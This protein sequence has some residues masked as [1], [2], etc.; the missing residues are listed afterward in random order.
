MVVGGEHYRTEQVSRMNIYEQL[1]AA[2]FS[3]SQAEVDHVKSKTEGL[4]LDE[5]AAQVFVLLLIGDR[6][7]DFELVERVKPG[8][9][10]RFFGEDLDF[11]MDKMK[12]L[13][14]KLPIPPLVTADMEG[15][16]LSFSFGTVV[17]NQLSLAAANDPALTEACAALMARE[18][19][20]L[21]VTWSFTPVIDIN[22]A[23]RSAIVG[24]RSY[25]SDRKTISKHALAHIKGLQENGIAATVKHWPGEGYDDRDQHFVT[26][27]N[28][29][30][31]D[32][33]HSTFGTLYREMFDAG[34]MSVMSAHIAFPA[35]MKALNPDCG[36]DAFKPAS[37]SYD[38]TTRLLRDEMGFNG[39]VVSDATEMA[40]LGSWI[41]RDKAA[42]EVLAAGCDVI[43]FSQDPESDVQAVVEAVRSGHLR[44]ERLNEAVARII[45][46]K[47]KQGILDSSFALP[48]GETLRRSLKRPEDLATAAEAM[49][50]APTL[51]KDVSQTLP[52]TT[53][54]YKR[55][56]VVDN[57]IRHTLWKDRRDFDVP[58]MLREKGFEVIRF[59][60]DTF[61]GKLYD[62][63][64]F[65]L[66]LYLLGDESVFTKSHIYIDWRTMI[67]GIERAMDRAWNTLP[68]VMVGFGHPYYLYDA[69][70]VPTYVNAYSTLPEMQQSVVDCLTGKTP[71]QGQSPVDAF[72]GLEDA[73]Y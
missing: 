63:D 42:P 30:T 45:A 61:E 16:H 64:R 65:D 67:G 26:T 29:L 13:F 11:E 50:R 36:V 44:E 12:R 55:I 17:P 59:D 40:G 8:G 10:T 28:P 21:G 48:D 23:F 33:W 24:S 37:I 62:P 58:R 53:E 70:R 52:L 39:I 25:G 51:V 34:V 15:S 38:L 1:R 2:P 66:V 22:V 5:K 20:Q 7:Q 6:E 18:A 32:E 57:Q 46:L 4:S 41:A 27:Q 3:L 47:L 72:C 68:T 19:R 9:I 69:P 14:S 73:R 71:F 60:Q 56:L 43:L 35:Y 54:R 31:L 49:R